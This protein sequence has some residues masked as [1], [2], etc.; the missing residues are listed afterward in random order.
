VSDSW[1]PAVILLSSVAIQALLPARRLVVVLAGAA[2]SALWSSLHGVRTA[3]LLHRIPWD[4]F[5]ILI[6]LGAVSELLAR[7]RAFDRMAVA[8]TRAGGARPA[9]V[10]LWFALLMYLVSGLVNNLTALLLV[11]PVLL[12]L[13]QLTGTTRRHLRWTVG[14]LITACNLGGASTPVGDFPAIL[15]LGAGAMQFDRYLLLAYPTC[16]ITLLVLLA[17]TA[18]GI[19]PAQDVPQ[20]DFGART[21]VAVIDALY[22]RVRIE[23]RVFVPAVLSL[24]GMLGFWL[25]PP[26]AAVSPELVAWLGATLLVTVVV[27]MRAPAVHSRSALSTLVAKAVDAEAA[28]FLF[29]LFFMV[30][31]VRATGLFESAADFLLALRTGNLIKLFLFMLSAG[32]LTGLFSAGPSMAAL[33]EVAAELS[34]VLPRDA[35]YVGLA[36]SVC[37]GSSLFLTAATAGPLAQ[38]MVD[39]E[40]LKDVRG[41]PLSFGFIEF[42]PVGLLSFCVIQSAALV[43]G[44]LLS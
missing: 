9:R 11:L 43:I 26:S 7:S 44:W 40:R 22:R 39:R 14:M 15:L 25:A 35:V 24:L 6:S 2:C 1:V 41:E 16:A 8:V 13:L 19:K 33:L 4:V 42:A 31:A 5:V 17:L 12:S 36:L 10:T 29:A 3:Q 30:G 21:T 34:K 18:W 32:V 38:G 23:R 27:A 28:L 37:A 20:T